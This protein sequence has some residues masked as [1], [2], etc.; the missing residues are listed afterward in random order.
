MCDPR[1]TR[2]RLDGIALAI[3]KAARE[4]LRAEGAAMSDA[5]V[6]AWSKTA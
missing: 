3:E 2:R 4:V 6:G 1:S 5:E